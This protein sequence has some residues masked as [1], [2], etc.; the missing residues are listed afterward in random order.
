MAISTHETVEGG[1]GRVEPRTHQVCHEVGWLFSDR[2]YPDEPR[3]PSLAMI[4]IV[5]ST[6]ERG[7]T[8]EHERRYYLCSAKLDAD[9]FARAVRS[10]WNIENWLHW[11]L[12]VVCHDDLARLRTGHGPANMAVIKHRALNLLHQARPTISLKNRRKRA[13][14]NADYLAAIIQQTT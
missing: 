9:T 12:D 6:T 4:G 13:G 7:G 11:G 2:R 10:H 1:H 3:F 8:V 5:E 14:W